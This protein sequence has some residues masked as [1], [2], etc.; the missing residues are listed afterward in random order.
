MADDRDQVQFNQPP[1]EVLRQ[2]QS[3]RDLT[4]EQRDARARMAA[5]KSRAQPHGGA[6]E[7]SIP[8]LH[9][10]PIPGGGT[11]QDQADA[12]RD[13]TNPLSPVYDPQM[14][15]QMQRRHAHPPQPKAG[16]PFAALPPEVQ[17][18]PRFIQGMG[19][20]IAGNQPHLAPKPQQ[21]DPNQADGYRPHLSDETKRSM[22]ALAQF[23][24]QAETGQQRQV[25]QT[26]AARVPQPQVPPGEDKQT[27]QLFEEDEKSLQE[28]LRELVGNDEMWTILNNPERKAAI[29]SRL[30]PMDLTDVIMY[31]EVRQDVPI[32]PG[33]LEVTFRSVSG[34]ED[35][36]VKQ[37]MGTE[38]GTDRYMLDKFTLMQLALGLVA[39]N[40]RELPTHLDGNKKFDEAKFLEKFEKVVRFPIQFLGDLGINYMW[41]DRRVRELF[42][43]QTDALKNS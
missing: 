40:G 36:R 27:D 17:K 25:H 31:G 43:G 5:I 20:M 19:S 13:P 2:R 32:Q 41:F 8:P 4:E 15:M 42:V 29:E 37:M 3:A 7:V 30:V 26:Q 12:L 38:Q 16:G 23:Q 11:M 22:E 1:D 18:D 35:L 6:P 9:A 39:I 10:Q 34:D 14:A 24:Q 21:N 28:E 33:K